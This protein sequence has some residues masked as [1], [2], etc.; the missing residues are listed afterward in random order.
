MSLDWDVTKIKNHKELVWREDDSIN[1]VSEMLIF[2]TMFVGINKITE[3]NWKEFL[4][5]LWMS[6]RIGGAMLR[7]RNKETGEISD[8][9][10][11]IQ[12]V[13]DHIGLSTNASPMTRAQFFKRLASTADREVDAWV[14]NTER[15]EAA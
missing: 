2:A 14:R 4:T 15:E 6:Q 5:R 9:P 10:L 11:D 8:R 1:P 3:K 12:D 13:K 7:Q